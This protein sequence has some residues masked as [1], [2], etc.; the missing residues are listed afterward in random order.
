MA[1]NDLIEIA[2]NIGYSL[3]IAVLGL[4]LNK[5]LKLYKLL[6]RLENCLDKNEKRTIWTKLH[7]FFN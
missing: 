4:F 2:K 1:A 5:A 3:I 7:D 6:K